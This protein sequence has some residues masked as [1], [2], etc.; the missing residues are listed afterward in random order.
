LR[1]NTATI[2]ATAAKKRPVERSEGGLIPLPCVAIVN[3]GG[4]IPLPCV[5]IVKVGLHDGIPCVQWNSFLPIL[6]WA[7]EDFKS[8]KLAGLQL[9]NDLTP[10]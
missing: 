5:A 9:H 8:W 3:V 10:D 6:R 7:A 2:T 1:H 4:L